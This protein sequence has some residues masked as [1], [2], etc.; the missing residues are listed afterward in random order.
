MQTQSKFTGP[1]TLAP[2]AHFP[3]S[4]CHFTGHWEAAG[5]TVYASHLFTGHWFILIPQG[6]GDDGQ[7]TE[8]PATASHPDLDTALALAAEHWL[9][10]PAF[11]QWGQCLGTTPDCGCPDCDAGEDPTLPF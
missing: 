8:A 2:D 5:R 1:I 3:G 9:G 10:Y 7:L 4:T 6:Q 11:D